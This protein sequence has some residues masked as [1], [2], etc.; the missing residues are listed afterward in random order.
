MCRLNK[1]QKI[2]CVIPNKPARDTHGP[3]I[4][5]LGSS[6]CFFAYNAHTNICKPRCR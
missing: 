1:Y 3:I 4:K 2:R 6:V 5:Q